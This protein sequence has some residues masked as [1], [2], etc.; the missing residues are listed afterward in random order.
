M[1]KEEFLNEVE[2][3][4]QN[5]PEWSRKGQARKRSLGMF[6]ITPNC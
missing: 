6:T 4:I 3:I 2:L 1:T 5:R